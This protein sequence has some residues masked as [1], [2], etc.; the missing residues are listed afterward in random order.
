MTHGS[1]EHACVGDVSVCQ[2]NERE[3]GEGEERREGER[4]YIA[5][6]PWKIVISNFSLLKN[7]FPSAVKVNTTS[8]TKH[9]LSFYK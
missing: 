9:H 7:K 3:R 6:R 1:K 5:I 8:S 2:R 4:E